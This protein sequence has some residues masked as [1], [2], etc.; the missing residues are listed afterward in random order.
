MPTYSQF[1]RLYFLGTGR[2][3]A[4]MMQAENSIYR[5]TEPDAPMAAFSSQTNANP[6]K[7]SVESFT[8]RDRYSNMKGISSDM[9]NGND[10]KY[11]TEVKSRL[12][13]FNNSTSISS[14]MFYSDSPEP[15]SAADKTG[16]ISQGI[17]KLKDSVKGFFDDMQRRIG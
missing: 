10:D 1:Q 7:S 16:D 14:D 2:I 11:A 17:S 5:K 15:N 6:N 4:A 8:A 12:E 9:L 13:M 3:S